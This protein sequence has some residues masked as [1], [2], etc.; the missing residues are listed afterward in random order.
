M[1]IKHCLSV[2]QLSNRFVL[3]SSSNKAELIV[4]YISDVK[5]WSRI[6]FCFFMTQPI[7]GGGTAESGGGPDCLGP[8]ER[9]AQ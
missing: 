4:V 9:G 8:A 3:P 1:E 5:Y 6:V 7:E 2:N